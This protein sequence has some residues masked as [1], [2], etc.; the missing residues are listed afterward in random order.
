MDILLIE[1]S[2]SIISGLEYS[3][4]INNYQIKSVRTIKEALLI[5]E[6]NRPKLIILD[7]TLPDGSGMSF[8][9]HILRKYEIP[10]IFLTARDSEEEIVKALNL[11]AE[12]YL[13]KP[14]FT[15]EL[16]A[17]VRKIILRNQN[18]AKIK[19]KDI[20]FDLD[21]M[22]VYKNDK[23]VEVS[24]LEL[25][26]LHL[27]FLNINKVVNREV[28]IDKLWE[29]TGNDVSDHT[30]TVYISRLRE[31]IG[32]EIIKTVKGIGYRIDEEE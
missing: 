7:I 21:K 12:D 15:K 13:T 31:K 2:E 26:I 14:F 28:I 32:D 3:F 18:N 23:K 30:I 17:R 6:K 19:V 4:K 16:L 8:Y 27:L 1:D 29:W 11:G 22:E 24:S 20:T 10:T 9:E 5:L 25:K